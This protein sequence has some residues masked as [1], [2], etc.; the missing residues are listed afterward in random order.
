MTPDPVRMTRRFRVMLA[1]TLTV[2]F[3]GC[4]GTAGAPAA[5][6]ADTTTLHVS[7]P[8]GD[9]WGAVE[10]PVTGGALASPQ[11][12]YRARN[13][14]QLVAALAAGGADAGSATAK[15]IFIE[16]AIDLSVGADNRPLIEADYRDPDFSW[17]AYAAAYDPQ[18][19]GKKAPSGALENARRRSAERQSAV[20]M[21]HVGSNT[22]LI[23]VGNKAIIRNGGLMLRG[24]HNVIIRNIAFEDAYD[25]FPQWDPKDNAN[26]EWN[27]EYDNVTLY[28]ARRVWIDRCSFSDGD[29]PDRRNRSLFGRPMQFHDGLLDI[30]RGADLVTVSNS[31]FR[32]HDKGLLIGNGDG[33]TDDDGKLRVTMHHNWFENVKERS[34]RVRYGR[35]HL[36][37]N[38]YTAN[39]GADYSYGYSIGVGVRSQI[40]AQNNV[41]ELPVQQSARV[42]KYW[43]GDRL[44][45]SGNLLNGT[46][47]DPLAMLRVEAPHAA[48]TGEVDW[49]PPYRVTIQDAADV[50]ATVRAAAGAGRT[51]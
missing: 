14:A 21:L 26:G 29:R 5:A 9:G 28:G 13:R 38:L 11:H 31:H 51:P 17:D 49:T 46:V 33:R 48:I 3:A 32:N 2:L 22:S 18:T 42:F 37:N 41:F 7:Q 50:A 8:A 47:F 43:R 36:F 45:A 6:S 34:P 44:L 12:V 40:I 24:A 35:V 20:V 25:Y 27:S 10:G 1:A 30:V 19:W 16:D 23:G 15:I 4:A 39:P